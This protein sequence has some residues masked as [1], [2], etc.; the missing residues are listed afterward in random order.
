MSYKL[1]CLLHV[2]RS[3]VHATPL[4]RRDCSGAWGGR[5]ARQ[6]TGRRPRSSFQLQEANFFR[7]TGFLAN[8]IIATCF[9]R[10]VP[11]LPFF[12]FRHRPAKAFKGRAYRR[13]RCHDER[14]DHPGRP[15]P[16]RLTVPQ[17]TSVHRERIYEGELHGRPIYS[18]DTG[19]ARRGYRLI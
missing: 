8:V 10:C 5:F 16:S 4:L 1:G 7:R 3:G 6:A 13:R 19:G 12:S 15:S 2:V 14:N 9:T 18:L 11:Y 17:D